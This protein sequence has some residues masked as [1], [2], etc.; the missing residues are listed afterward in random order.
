MSTANPICKAPKHIKIGVITDLHYG[1]GIREWNSR[2]YSL[3]L[4]K[5]SRVFI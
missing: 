2:F 1:S 4:K 3:A 5:V